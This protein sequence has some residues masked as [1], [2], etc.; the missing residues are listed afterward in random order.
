M[1]TVDFHDF[2]H[3]Y[4]SGFHTY[5]GIIMLKSFIL[6]SLTSFGDYLISGTVQNLAELG[7]I[8]GRPASPKLAGLT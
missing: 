4:F 7:E 3:Q 8:L 6:M 1:L 5:K 2:Y